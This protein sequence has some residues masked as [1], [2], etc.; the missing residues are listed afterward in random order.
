MCR[1]KRLLPCL[2]AALLLTACSSA[3]G[4]TTTTAN[5]PI[6][7]EDDSPVQLTEIRTPTPT[8][9]AGETGVPTPEQPDRPDRPNPDQG[10][11]ENQDGNVQDEIGE[12][13][14]L[15]GYHQLFSYIDQSS[16]K[17][18]GGW[19][20]HEVDD[21][22][23]GLFETTEIGSN[24]YG[25][26]LNSVDVTWKM[27]NSV[28]VSAYVIYTANDTDTYPERNP[29]SWTLYGSND[30]SDW[31]KIHSVDDAQL[32]TTNYTP[33]LYEFRNDTAYRYYRWS[34]SSTVGGAGPFQLSE[35]LLY[36]AKKPPKQQ[37]HGNLDMSSLPDD[38]PELGASK[39]GVS[40][41]PLIGKEAGKWI[42]EHQLLN[43]LLQSSS[44]AS[45]IDGFAPNEQVASL[46]DGIYTEDEFVVGGYGKFC[47]PAEN[48]YVYWEMTEAVTPTG[49]GLVTGNDTDE[50]PER[51]PVS[52][53]LY[54]ATEDGEWVLLDAVKEGNL[55]EENFAMH[56][57][58]IDN[59]HAYT[60]F[61]F[62]LENQSGTIQLSELLLY[63]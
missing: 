40:A 52:W 42:S 16:I 14:E 31:K 35:L 58:S 11:N 39:M 18:P 19:P 60:R 32:P 30:G 38:L 7:W 41:S 22:L 10:G 15:K 37:S 44:I 63:H 49:Y 26:N 17:G 24:K 13:A 55:Q 54:G 43:D 59:A 34:M 53:A 3:M 50:Y 25:E 28:T 1:I 12:G 20:K 56:V 29:N 46:F 57:F 21:M 62:A 6:E 33:T 45:S 27:T 2:L 48:G 61:C 4:E 36:S 8:L 5:R 23:D 47:G 9:P 51:N